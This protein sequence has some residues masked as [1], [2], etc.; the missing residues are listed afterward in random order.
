MNREDKLK[1]LFKTY[2]DKTWQNLGEEYDIDD[3]VKWVI[4]DKSNIID[5]LQDK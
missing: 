3:I 1:S 5:I 4:D 2:A